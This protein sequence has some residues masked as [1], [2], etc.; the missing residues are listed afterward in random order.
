MKELNEDNK[1]MKTHSTHNHG[2]IKLNGP[3]PAHAF[4]HLILVGTESLT[5][6]E[7]KLQENKGTFLEDD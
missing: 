2:N 1:P 6:L 3:S 7:I 5:L 4:K